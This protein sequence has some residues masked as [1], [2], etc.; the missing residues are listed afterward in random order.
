[1]RKELLIKAAVDQKEWNEKIERKKK[2]NIHEKHFHLIELLER[3]EIVRYCIY[4]AL[5]GIPLRY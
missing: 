3:D 1:M 2:L 4:C 5:I